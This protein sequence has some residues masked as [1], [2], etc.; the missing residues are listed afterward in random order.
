MPSTVSART[1]KHGS[2]RK[3]KPLIE[4][5]G[6]GCGTPDPRLDRFIPEEIAPL[7]CQVS[8]TL[9]VLAEKVYANLGNTDIS[10]PNLGE[11]RAQSVEASG[12]RNEHARLPPS[13]TGEIAPF[14]TESTPCRK[15]Q[16]LGTD[17]M[18][19]KSAFKKMKSSN[20]TSR[21]SSILGCL[22]PSIILE[23]HRPLLNTRGVT[24]WLLYLKFWK[25]YSSI[26]LE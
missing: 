1:K 25:K 13:V 19:A 3:N 22:Q 14:M 11:M 18:E 6:Q 8:S 2:D 17:E 7:H 16:F 26:A 4:D 24:I 5:T 9:A 20:A 10:V 15:R 23:T 12:R 21:I